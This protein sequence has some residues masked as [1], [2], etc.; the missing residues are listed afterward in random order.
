MYI[1]K[2]MEIQVRNVSKYFKGIECISEV[3]FTGYAGEIVGVLAPVGSGKTLLLD[4]LRGKVV[5]D[6]GSV[7]YLD[8]NKPIKGRHL[9]Q[10][11]GYLDATNALYEYMTV[12]D[13]LYFLT[14]LYKLPH[15]L[16]KERVRNLIKICGLS[17]RKHKEIS[18]LSKGS[19]QRVGIAQALI[20]NP[21][22]LLLDEPVSGLDPSQSQQLYE[23]IKE[24]GKERTV[25]L[26]S[27]RMRDV[28]NMCDTMLVLSNGKVLAKGTVGELQEEVANSSIL[29][30]R[31]GGADSL[32]AYNALQ[33][34]DYIQVISN[35]ELSFEIHTT[36]EERFSKD[37]FSLCAEKGWY[38]VRLV[39][40]EKSLED[41]FKQL[42]RN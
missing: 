30:L 27:S 1:C 14:S 38:I 6:S 42:R 10:Y 22:F 39:A 13:Y 9:K 40:A 17:S 32:A 23:L 41:I 37:L 3:T 24:Q 12:Y 35:K 7:T 15:Y 28:E 36:K 5:P 20:H 33:Q 29:K 18:T 2:S 8:D 25:I 34:L 21:P 19:R 26:T 11:I 31:I 16:R 4:L